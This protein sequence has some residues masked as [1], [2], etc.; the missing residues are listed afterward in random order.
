MNDYNIHINIR[1]LYKEDFEDFKNALEETTDFIIDER[2]REVISDKHQ[3]DFEKKKAEQQKDEESEDSKKAYT[4]VE[5][6]DI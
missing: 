5:F 6:E 2:G 1:S 3:P 4:N